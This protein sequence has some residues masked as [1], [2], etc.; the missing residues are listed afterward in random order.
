MSV[1]PNQIKALSSSTA[2]IQNKV[3][4]LKT[5]IDRVDDK[6]DSL[7]FY[8]KSK[9]DDL[10]KVQVGCPETVFAQRLIKTFPEQGYNHLI[11]KTI[12]NIVMA[13]KLGNTALEKL[14]SEIPIDSKAKTTMVKGATT[15][16]D[17]YDS[18]KLE[19]FWIG[20][21][22]KLQAG[23]SSVLPGQKT[24]PSVPQTAPAKSMKELATSIKA[25]EESKRES[26]L[27][28]RTPR[29]ASS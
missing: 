22:K 19:D 8:A 26:T 23:Y 7:S 29:P 9:S 13:S 5:C 16:R 4:E 20:V 17:S 6:V 1:I 10:A 15:I 21:M 28:R 25:A 11:E 3:L 14:L 12:A 24:K 2:E 27:D 18:P